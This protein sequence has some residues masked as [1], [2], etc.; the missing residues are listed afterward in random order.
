MP[1]HQLFLVKD[2]QCFQH[3]LVIV[4]CRRLILSGSTYLAT[5]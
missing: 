1:S 2:E 4:A 5:V 3:F